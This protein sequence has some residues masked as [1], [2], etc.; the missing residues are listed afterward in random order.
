MC[1]MITCTLIAQLIRGVPMLFDTLT[2]HT[3][4]HIQTTIIV[5]PIFGRHDG[6]ERRTAWSFRSEEG[7]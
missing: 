2:G 3:E 7:L 5:A 6:T 1:E 4:E